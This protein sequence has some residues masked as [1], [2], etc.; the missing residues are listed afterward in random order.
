MSAGAFITLM[1][2]RPYGFSTIAHRGAL[3]MTQMAFSGKFN[4]I[5]L[6][7]FLNNAITT[8][9]CTWACESHCASNRQPTT[10]DL[11]HV[12]IS[13]G[14]WQEG[15]PA[16][17]R[18]ALR[19]HQSGTEGPQPTHSKVGQQVLDYAILD[20]RSECTSVCRATS[21]SA[22]CSSLCKSLHRLGVFA[23]VSGNCRHLIKTQPHYQATPQKMKAGC[24]ISAGL[25]LLTTFL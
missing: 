15:L 25:S 13:D 20:R 24:L 21:T 9:V 16:A 7:Y 5:E 12:R 1:A 14:R 17:V 18:P 10:R 11:L 6:H 2:W 23:V 4:R 3:Q 22:T 8:S 19:W